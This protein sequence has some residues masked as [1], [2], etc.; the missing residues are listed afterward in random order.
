[1]SKLKEMLR[2]GEF[3]T[4]TDFGLELEL[5]EYEKSKMKLLQAH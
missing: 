3:R 4:F 2:D 5:D 1:V